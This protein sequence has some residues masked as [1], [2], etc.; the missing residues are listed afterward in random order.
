M[1]PFDPPAAR[2]SPARR[3]A[4]RAGR[5]LSCRYRCPGRLA[6]ASLVLSIMRAAAGQEHYRLAGEMLIEAKEQV[7]YGGWGRWL[8]KNF[9][10]SERTARDY[11]RWAREYNK[12][13][14]GAA[15]LPYASLREMTG[16]TERDR[17][18][19]TSTQQQQFRRALRDVAR[20]DFIQ[21]RQ[22]GNTSAAADVPD[23]R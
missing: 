23:G 9:D 15:E 10:L 2:G 5:R 21:E 13:G 14:S 11:M 4:P 19:R 18:H 17:E 12:S 22:L 1:S 7:G 3:A 16:H 20:D 6:G 8:T